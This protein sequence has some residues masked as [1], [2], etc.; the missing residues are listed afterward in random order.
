ML[1]DSMKTSQLILFLNFLLLFTSCYGQ[2]NEK[3]KKIDFVITNDYMSERNLSFMGG[4]IPA[5]YKKGII[6]SLG[7]CFLERYDSNNNIA[8]EKYY[9]KIGALYRTNK[10][11][12]DSKNR[13][14]KAVEI[15]EFKNDTC[16]V[17]YKYT[18]SLNLTTRKRITTSCKNDFLDFYYKYNGKGEKIEMLVKENDTLYRREIIQQITKNEKL[19]KSYD[20]QNRLSSYVYK[21]N[22]KDL[23]VYEKRKEWDYV[24]RGDY[25]ETRQ[26]NEIL[27]KYDKNGNWTERTTQTYCTPKK[28]ILKNT[29][30]AKQ[31]NLV[32]TIKPKIIDDNYEDCK[33]EI[34][35]KLVRKIYYK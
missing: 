9:N 11:Y 29:K 33:P 13:I 25:F 21:Y 3:S 24:R 20:A 30:K 27:Y 28:S 10:K 6:D 35:E 19:I 7:N 23:L 16:V 26:E 12:Y 17:K 22:D 34:K 18:D 4:P 5:N 32:K 1:K 31:T 8:E 14:E 15:N 2:T